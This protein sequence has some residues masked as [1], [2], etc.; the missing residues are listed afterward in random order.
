MA[1]IGTTAHRASRCGQ[2]CPAYYTTAYGHCTMYA[3]QRRL[4]SKTCT[5]ELSYQQCCLHQELN[6]NTIASLCAPNPCIT[7]FTSADLCK[8][9][10]RKAIT[11]SAAWLVGANTL[12]VCTGRADEQ[13]CCSHGHDCESG[14]DA[15]GLTT[16]QTSFN[17]VVLM[18]CKAGST[19]PCPP[20]MSANLGMCSLQCRSIY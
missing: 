19:P 4:Q 18:W 11:H 17:A 1:P 7:L 12:R 10:A 9:T 16:L 8:S 5:C 2:Y 15:H 20:G 13:R 3:V 6:L 14:L